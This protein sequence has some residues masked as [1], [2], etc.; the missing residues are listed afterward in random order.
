MAKNRY[1]HRGRKLNLPVVD[2]NGSGDGNLCKSGDPGMIGRLAVVCL[3]DEDANGNATVDT[4][5]VYRF[6]GVTTPVGVAI[7]DSVNWNNAAG[8]LTTAADDGLGGP[9]FPFF[10]TL[11]GPEDVTDGA[12]QTIEVR[13][14][15]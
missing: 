10:G 4:L 6:T 13:V 11:V 14:G 1:R 12:D 8:E 15:Y 5:G 3:T 2:I 9:A 7:G